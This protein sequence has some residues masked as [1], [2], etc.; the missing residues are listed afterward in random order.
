[1]NHDKDVC[2]KKL[3]P[4]QTEITENMNKLL[5]MNAGAE[6]LRA[7]KKFADLAV[8]AAFVSEMPPL[9]VAAK[10]LQKG[11]DLAVF[12]FTKVQ[13]FYLG[14]IQ[15]HLFTAGARVFYEISK[16]PL[17]I[18]IFFSEN[19]HRFFIPKFSKL[20]L[21]KKDTLEPFLFEL[22]TDPRANE[23][24][25]LFVKWTIT[26]PLM[27]FLNKFLK[28]PRLKIANSCGFTYK[29]ISSD[30]EK[31]ETIYYDEKNFSFPF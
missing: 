17:P 3:G 21:R 2:Q 19:L 28:L 20:A 29:K 24:Q 4:I 27:P 10:A 31:V 15:F 12:T 5:S 30:P 22:S 7:A 14:K 6:G 1:M 9:I 25:A 13:Q 23:K 26:G 16:E 8:D 18:K 11:V